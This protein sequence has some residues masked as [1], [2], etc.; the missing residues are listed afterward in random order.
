LR[1]LL[2]PGRRESLLKGERLRRRPVRPK[3]VEPL[4]RLLDARDVAGRS[5]PEHEMR[6]ARRLEP[7]AT[8]P[9]KLNVAAAMGELKQLF[10][11]LPDREVDDDQ[12]VVPHAHRGRVPLRCLMPP[13]EAGGRIARPVGA[14]EVSDEIGDLAQDRRDCLYRTPWPDG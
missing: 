1:V 13:D 3:I 4:L 6:L 5:P 8:P 9:V 14:V 2:S 12:R 7:L 10:D 11:G